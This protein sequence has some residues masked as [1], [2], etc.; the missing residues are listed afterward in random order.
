MDISNNF[1]NRIPIYQQIRKRIDK[2]E[3]IKL[4]NCTAKGTV[5]D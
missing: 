5:T 4:K 2:W 3:Y 1:L